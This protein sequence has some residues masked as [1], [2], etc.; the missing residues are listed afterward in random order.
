MKRAVGGMLLLIVAVSAFG[1]MLLAGPDQ[2]GR[3][4]PSGDQLSVGPA[5]RVEPA[6]DDA[7]TRS[8]EALKQP[9]EITPQSIRP[10]IPAATRTLLHRVVDNQACL[11][12]TASAAQPAKTA[13]HRWVD[14]KGV[15]HFSD[16]APIGPAH[17]Y[18]QIDAQGL[19][20]IVVHARGYDVNLPDDLVQNAIS[21][22]QAIERILRGTLGVEGEPG[23]VLDVE[24]V[25]AADA[26][27]K[28]A[29]NPVMASSAGT[30][31]PQNRTIH[32]R[33]QADEQSNLLILHHEITHAL[34]HERVGRLPTA[35]NEGMA[36]Y[37]EH[38]A[39][40][41]MGALVT[42]A[43]SPGSLGSARIEGDGQV[44]LVDLFA[45]DGADFYAQG[46]EQRYLRAY[47]LIALLMDS[48][49]GRTAL[50]AVLAAQRGQPCLP[51]KAEAILDSRYPGGL[52]ALTRDW[53]AW[54]G[55]PPHS[56]RSW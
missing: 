47:A 10:D 19:P 2:V 27:A 3:E 7:A 37:F 36:G 21:A 56:V 51:V 39:V 35:I 24:F 31:S 46:Q 1:F 33:L 50:A 4:L 53:V 29:G 34:I 30:Y 6:A 49:P 5:S 55:A 14:A 11:A 12:G 48:G 54:L 22:A 32:I 23:L 9:T 8:V 17:G 44:E 40:S 25:A 13:I 42:I 28:R 52:A 45:H 43:D 26:W 15:I 16:L 41:G 38:L 18:R 20:A